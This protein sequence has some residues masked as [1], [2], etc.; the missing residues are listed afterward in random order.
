[1]APLTRNHFITFEGGEGTGKSTQVRLLAERLSARGEQVTTTREP[2]GSPQ[3]E[4][5]REIIL[6]GKAKEFGAFAETVLFSAARIDH[7]RETILPA[8]ERGS[9]VI[10]DRFLDSTRAYQGALGNLDPRILRGLEKVVVGETMP[11]LTIL[12]DVPPE[13]G[14]ER[15]RSRAGSAAPDRFESEEIEYHRGLRRAFLD[16][17]QAEPQ[18]IVVIDAQAEPDVVAEKVWAEVAAHYALPAA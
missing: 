11:G 13:I 17:A 16:L 9:W 7:L 14:L 5:L 4:H 12:L 3:A 1:M 6:S 8:L 2:G 10:C 15:A 18:R